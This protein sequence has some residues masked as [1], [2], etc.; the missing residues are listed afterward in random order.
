MRSKRQNNISSDKTMRPDW[1]LTD[2]E[3]EDIRQAYQEGCKG[4]IL[5]G[6]RREERIITLL[7]P[8]QSSSESTNTL[9]RSLNKLNEMGCNRCYHVSQKALT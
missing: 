7:L 2:D 3:I 8:A 9:Q 4:E 5:I 6:M 1:P